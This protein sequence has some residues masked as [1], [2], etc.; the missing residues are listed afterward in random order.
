MT[1]TRHE[2]DGRHF[3]LR[4]QARATEGANAATSARTP[5]PCSPAA[6]RRPAGT[7]HS[8]ARHFRAALHPTAADPHH[9]RRKGSDFGADTTALPAGR[10]TAAGG[11][12]AQYGPAPP[13]RRAVTDEPQSG[14]RPEHL[15]ALPDRLGSSTGATGLEPSS[16][17]VPHEQ[18]PAGRATPLPDLRN[19]GLSFTRNSGLAAPTSLKGSTMGGMRVAPFSAV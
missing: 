16:G 2:R 3:T 14:R 5:P 6:E 10:R 15:S 4:W 8:T 12:P 7:Q 1:R 17:R 13:G 19:L 11:H 9:R 18:P